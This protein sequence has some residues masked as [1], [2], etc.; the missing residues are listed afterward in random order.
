M[1]QSDVELVVTQIICQMLAESK[2]YFG[3]VLLYT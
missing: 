1:D 2:F 3:V